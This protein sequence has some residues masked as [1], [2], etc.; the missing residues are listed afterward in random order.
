LPADLHAFYV[1]VASLAGLLI[2]S[3]LNVCIYR[4]PR[5]LSVITPRSFCPRCGVPISWYDN[6]PLFSY[7]RLRGRCR[8]CSQLVGWRYP[9]VEATTAVLFALVVGEYGWTLVALK[10]C[11]FDALLIALFWTDLEERILPDE[12]TLGG[13]AAGLVFAI[14]SAVPSAFP[15][16]LF[17]SFQPVFQSLIAAALGASLAAVVWL[18][19]AVYGWIRK[20]DALGLGDVKLIVLLGVFLGLERALFALVIGTVAGSVLGLSYILLTRRKVSSYELPLGTFL[21]AGGVLVPLLTR[22]L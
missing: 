21:C 2:G 18:I 9:L 5:D 7:L 4:L 15:S 8:A 3:F 1:A 10:W 20:R 11:V 12:L 19:G 17:P 22:W 14:F 6:V 16:V 13:A